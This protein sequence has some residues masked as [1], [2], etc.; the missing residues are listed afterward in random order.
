MAAIYKGS[1][2]EIEFALTSDNLNTP[3]PRT[4]MGNNRL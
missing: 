4:Y 3:P 1:S 2:I